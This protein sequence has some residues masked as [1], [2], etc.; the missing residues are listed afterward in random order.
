MCK[1]FLY[2]CDKYI[3]TITNKIIFLL[4]IKKK[5]NNLYQELKRS[6]E[7]C[8]LAASFDRITKLSPL[9][10]CKLS[11]SMLWNNLVL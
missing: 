2:K 7:P 9:F 5:Q 1:K 8:S 11:E 3:H 10:M 6:Q 4:S